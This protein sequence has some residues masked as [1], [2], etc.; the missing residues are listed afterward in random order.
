MA[1]YLSKSYA[2]SFEQIGASHHLPACD[3]WAIIRNIPDTPYRDAMGCYPLFSCGSWEDLGSDL[4]SFPEHTVAFSMV[5]DPLGDFT[6]ADLQSVFTD[7]CRP[8]KQ[9]Y[10][11]DLEKDVSPVIASNH[12]RN[13]KKAL[14]TLQIEACPQPSLQVE[15]WTDLYANLIKRHQIKGI[16]AFSRAAFQK[17]FETPGLI[18]YQAMLED[19]LAGMVMFY[20]MDNAVYYHLAAY[21]DDG[22]AHRASFGIFYKAIQDFQSKNLKW[23][24]MGGGAGMTDSD[25]NGLVR[26]KKGWTSETRT[27]WL[28]G[29]VL[30]KP[31][32]QMLSK[33]NP[34]ASDTFFPAYRSRL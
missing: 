7:L 23:L 3:G 5:T 26:F 17:Q 9:H 20:E 10:I 15:A 30:H 18:V 22:Y 31:A 34:H 19:N 27:A 1:G 29:K 2:A 14:K 11:L 28:C 13:A 33:Q 24:N 12:L 6:D 21:T 4:S 32:Y 16:S 8:F 25:E